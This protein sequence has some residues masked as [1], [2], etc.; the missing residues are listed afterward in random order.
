K[1]TVLAPRCFVQG[2]TEGGGAKDG[3]GGLWGCDM[4]SLATCFAPSFQMARYRKLRRRQSLWKGTSFHLNG[5]EIRVSCAEC[6]HTSHWF[7]GCPPPLWR[8][9]RFGQESELKT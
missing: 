7:L 9:P 5:I 1:W 6:F 2:G 8:S 4:T 3:A